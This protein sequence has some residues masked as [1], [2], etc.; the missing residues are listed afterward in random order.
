MRIRILA[1]GNESGPSIGE[2]TE[3][4]KW[5]LSGFCDLEVIEVKIE[6]KPEEITPEHKEQAK[7]IEAERLKRYLKPEGSYT[8]LLDAGG[9][10]PTSEG[11]AEMLKKFENDE[12]IKCLDFVVGGTYGVTEEIR[13]MADM[14]FSLSNMTFTHLVARYLLMEQLYR[15]FTIL[16]DIPYNF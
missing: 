11:V 15:G 6:P 3:Y 5:K 10:Q 8:I 4:I 16:N 2:L 7:Q 1:V 14:T 12:S 13:Q 9:E